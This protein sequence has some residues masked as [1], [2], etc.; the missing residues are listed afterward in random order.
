MEHII[1]ETI[2]KIYKKISENGMKLETIKTKQYALRKKEQKLKTKEIQLI[3]E[4]NFFI[5]LKFISRKSKQTK[6]LNKYKKK[7]KREKRIKQETSHN[8]S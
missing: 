6:M 4:Y 5:N 8:R 2:D 3:E 1:E 7:K